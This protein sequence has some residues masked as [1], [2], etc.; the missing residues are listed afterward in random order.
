MTSP[1]PTIFSLDELQIELAQEVRSH[2]SS[3]YQDLYEN[4]DNKKLAAERHLDQ[5]LQVMK[6][7]PSTSTCRVNEIFSTKQ[8][9]I[10]GLKQ[11]LNTWKNRHG[12][13]GSENHADDSLVT[14][15]PL[16]SDMVCVDSS[17]KSE[18]N[19]NLMSKVRAPRNQGDNLF[20]RWIKREE[21]G[22]PLSHRV[23][24]CDRFCGE[25]VLRGS[26]IFVRG[27]ICADGGIRPGE[28]VAVY[29]DLNDGSYKTIARGLLLEKYPGRCVFL[30][31]GR[32]CCSRADMFTLS[33]G[34]A[35]EM[36]SQPKDRAGSVHPPLHGAMPGKFML[37]NLPSAVVAHVLSPQPG[38]VILDMCS[39]PGGKTTHVASLVRND[40]TIVAC[41]RSRRK[42]VSAR[43][44]FRTMGAA[45]ITP[46][47]LDSTSCVIRDG[48]D[49]K[50]VKE[51]SPLSIYTLF[52]RE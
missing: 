6:T 9:V 19:E 24:I 28:E 30:G 21:T 11:V 12:D 20:P 8:E 22:W 51:V 32:A 49:N 37:Q 35:V 1:A 13:A 36:S 15:H 44:F 43:E 7:A 38:D 40:A 42:M 29:A 47:A 17:S 31:L 52:W 3:Q 34:V 45:C 14:I 25:A 10:E 26:D 39:A 18:E 16:L 48:S 41:D 2:L 5:V 27:V 33:T 4:D 23:I 46:L 50:E